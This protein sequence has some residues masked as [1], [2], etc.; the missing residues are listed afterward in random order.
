MLRASPYTQQYRG[1]HI[2]RKWFPEADSF[3]DLISVWSK[4]QW[5]ALRKLICIRYAY[6]IWK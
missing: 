3:Y 6:G 5:E 1:R 4:G 2:F